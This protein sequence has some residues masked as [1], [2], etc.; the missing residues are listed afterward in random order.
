VGGGVAASS[1]QQIFGGCGGAGTTSTDFAGGAFTAIGDS[2]SL[3]GGL[4]TGGAGLDGYTL[5]ANGLWM[6]FL[7]A[8]GTGG[9]SNNAGTGG[10]GGNGGLGCGGG[11]GGAGVTGGAGGNGGDGMV[12]IVAV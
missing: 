6:P 8:P 5:S 9:G 10:K 3:A 12:V 7:Y 1:G 11:G 2:P 4:A